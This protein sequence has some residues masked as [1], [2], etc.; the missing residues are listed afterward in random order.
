MRYQRRGSVTKYSVDASLVPVDALAHHLARSITT[1]D[2]DSMKNHRPHQHNGNTTHS[3]DSSSS[4]ADAAP[5]CA[6]IDS[7]PLPMKKK[8]SA[9]INK[10]G[11]KKAG[12]PINKCSH[13]SA[14]QDA[15]ANGDDAREFFSERETKVEEKSTTA[16]E[17]KQPIANDSDLPLKKK[18]KQKKKK[19]KELN[20]RRG[21]EQRASTTSI[22]GATKKRIKQ[23]RRCSVTKYNLKQDLEIERRNGNLPSSILPTLVQ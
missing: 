1:T 7:L 8:S 18:T 12:D 20:L 17:N 2:D 14:K 10:G 11:S 15:F 4:F 23:K 5:L 9:K 22:N 6:T 3:R 19:K 21:Q 16:A 13:Q